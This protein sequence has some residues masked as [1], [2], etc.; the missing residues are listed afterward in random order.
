MVVFL[1]FFGFTR[2]AYLLIITEFWDLSSF[3]GAGEGGDGAGSRVGGWAGLAM[4][5][6]PAPVNE[7]FVFHIKKGRL[8]AVPFFILRYSSIILE[9]LK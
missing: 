4:Q 2:S 5:P 7:L 9:F 1:S 6:S 3:G 8:Y